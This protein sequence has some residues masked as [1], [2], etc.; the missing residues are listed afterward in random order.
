MAI[1]SLDTLSSCNSIPGFISGNADVGLVTSRLTFNQTSA[2]T[3]WT[4]DTTTHNNKALRVVNTASLVPGGS[5]AFTVAFPATKTVAGTIVQ[6]ITGVSVQGG[7]AGV[8]ITA[9]QSGVVAQ[10]HALSIA[11]L[12]AH[13]HDYQFFVSP[14]LSRIG[15]A[16]SADS[17]DGNGS[18]FNQTGSNTNHD[19]NITEATHN[20]TINNPSHPHADTDI[21]H[22]H[23]FTGTAQDFA[24]NYVDV[25]IAFKN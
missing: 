6:N 18:T 21:Q 24:V 7:P 16:E 5:Q 10:Q 19:H 3:S 22:N 15:P 20:H 25:I 11:Q 17:G 8:T 1:L 23:T 9:A 2:P 14:T 13:T 4:K 12:P